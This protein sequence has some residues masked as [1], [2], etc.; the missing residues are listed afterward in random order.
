MNRNKINWIFPIAGY[1]TRT[2]Q[3]GQYKP[4]IDIFPNKSILNICL[5]GLKTIIKDEDELFFICSKEQN[6][7]YFVDSSIKKI[8]NNI[9]LT[10]QWN[11][12]ELDETPKGQALTIKN[13]MT[14]VGLTNNT[15]GTFVINSDQMVF[16]DFQ[17]IDFDKCSVGLYFNDKP[18]S[19]F[20]D[21]DIKSKKIINIR[22]KEQ[23]TCYASSGVFYFNSL[24]KM[25]EC[26]EWGIRNNKQYNGELYLGPC[27]GHIE[28]LKYFQNI[29]K[30]DLGNPQKIKL[31]KQF[32]KEITT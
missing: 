8:L 19:C 21:L 25:L 23:I 5:S 6:R 29:I 16:F 7:K 32:F 15:N 14:K 13:A 27:M 31:F 3:L 12:I 28:D 30:F 1:G 4:L 20:Y 26:I 18:S 10:N 24:K 17:D 9:E 22:E 2:L 11:L